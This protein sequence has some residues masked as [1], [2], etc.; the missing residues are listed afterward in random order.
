MKTY[1]ANW[2]KGLD[3]AEKKDKELRNTITQYI[4][5][6]IDKKTAV[7]TVLKSSTLGAGYNAQI[8]HDFIG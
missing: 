2:D 7:E 1:T 8:R 3:W 5:E 4:S 6:G